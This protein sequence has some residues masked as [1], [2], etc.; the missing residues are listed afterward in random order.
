MKTIYMIYEDGWGHTGTTFTD[1]KSAELFVKLQNKGYNNLY[2]IREKKLYDNLEEYINDNKSNFIY[3]L[4]K[5]IYNMTDRYTKHTLK[6]KNGLNKMNFEQI[7][8][9]V[10][11]NK[12]NFSGWWDYNDKYCKVVESDLQVVIHKYKEI[13]KQLRKYKA[14][15]KVLE[16]SE[17]LEESTMKAL[18]EN[19]SLEL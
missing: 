12:V 2:F 17:N 18:K 14:I 16:K 7:K 13:S 3:D 10:K 11:E 19:L 1:K 9:I 15:I 6:F 8:E 5:V 4:K